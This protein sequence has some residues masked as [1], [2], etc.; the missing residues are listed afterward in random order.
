MLSDRV[1]TDCYR[2]FFYFLFFYFFTHTTE[3]TTRC[4]ATACAPIAIGDTCVKFDDIL[5][6]QYTHYD[7][8]SKYILYTHY[9][10]HGTLYTLLYSILSTHTMITEVNRYSIH[11][12]LYTLLYTRNSIHTALLYTHYTHYCYRRGYILYTH[13]TH[14]LLPTWLHTIK[15]VH[16]STPRTAQRPRS[17]RLLSVSSRISSRISSRL[18]TCMHTLGACSTVSYI[19]IYYI[20]TILYTC[21]ILQPIYY[22]T[23]TATVPRH[24]L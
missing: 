11:T 22:Y 21:Y 10:I 18:Y 7:Y 12:T 13:Y 19:V 23:T 15:Y 1:R 16:W 3:Y 9:S 2:W 17:H 6:T 14:Y 24:L 4:S 5:Y 20:R 8:R